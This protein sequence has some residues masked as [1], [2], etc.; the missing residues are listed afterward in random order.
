MKS[1]TRFRSPAHAGSF[2]L[3]LLIGVALGI[4]S[5]CVAAYRIRMEQ[6]A[7]REQ[8]L[9]ELVDERTSALRESE[10]KL[11]QSRDQLDLRVQERTRELTFAN[12]ALGEE[13]EQSRQHCRIR[14]HHGR[15]S[16]DDALAW[17]LGTRGGADGFAKSGPAAGNRS[18]MWLT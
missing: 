9:L 6:I 8:K 16:E 1:T 3:I 18:R 11:R 2:V 7:M 13:I 10:A 15:F 17:P 4:I 5:L 14:D 12:K